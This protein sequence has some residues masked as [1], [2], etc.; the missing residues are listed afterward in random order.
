MTQIKRFDE[1][2]Q[3]ND[4]TKWLITDVKFI[5]SRKFI[6]LVQ[7]N[8]NQTSLERWKKNAHKNGELHKQRANM[9]KQIEFDRKLIF[10][11]PILE[12]CHHHHDNAEVLPNIAQECVIFI[13]KPVFSIMSNIYSHFKYQN[14]KLKEKA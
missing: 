6:H 14:N 4:P 8:A 7:R 10:I 9:P 2:S 1:M 5:P 12:H 13:H 3:C 11:N